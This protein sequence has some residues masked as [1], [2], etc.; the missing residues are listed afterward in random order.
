MPSY[1]MYIVR[2]NL[3]TIID[4]DESIARAVLSAA[5]HDGYGAE[6]ARNSEGDM[7]IYRGNRHI[8]NN[9]YHRNDSDGLIFPYSALE[10]DDAAEIELA[11]ALWEK[12]NLHVRFDMTIQELTYED[13]DILTHVDGQPI[14]EYHRDIHGDDP[15]VT[16]Q[17]TIDLF[18]Y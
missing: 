11:K 5:K 4:A 2:D 3:G 6:F 13:G 12:G 10:D 17:D 1:N 16:I 8:G 9:T 15:D 7:V 18:E 14:A